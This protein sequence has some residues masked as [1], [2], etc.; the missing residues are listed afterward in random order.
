MNQRLDDNVSLVCAK[1][2]PKPGGYEGA[3]PGMFVGR[4]VKK[5]FES[6]NPVEGSDG[7]EHMWVMVERIDAGE[8]VGTLA[9]EPAYESAFRYGDEVRVRIVEI[10]AVHPPFLSS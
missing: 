9:N 10:E 8:L 3:A 2:A 6:R 5:R 1:H 7:F 4:A